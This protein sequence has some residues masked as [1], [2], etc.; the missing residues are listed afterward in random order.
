LNKYAEVVNN[1]KKEKEDIEK[2]YEFL[3]EISTVISDSSRHFQ[4]F[5][6]LSNQTDLFEK[7]LKI[8]TEDTR[9]LNEIQ[10]EIE[11]LKKNKSIMKKNIR[12]TYR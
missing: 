11:E 5:K 1:I 2:E 9:T 6:K 4:E 3:K 12:C 10:T 8:L 7:E